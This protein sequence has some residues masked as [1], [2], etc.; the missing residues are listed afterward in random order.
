MNVLL[1]IACLGVAAGLT[2]VRTTLEQVP[3]VDVGGALSAPVDVGEPRNILIIGT[4]S[5]KG[6]DK[7]DPV[8]KGRL[9]GENLADVIM[10]LRVDPTDGS[11]RLLSIP[12]DSRVELPDGSMQ[13]INAAIAGPQGPKNLVQTIKRNF[14]ISIDNYLEVDFAAFK[15]LVEVLGS[16]P[17][18]FTT[19]VR[20][21]TTG[22]YVDNAG[23]ISLSPDQALAYAR[24]RHFE[25]KA[26]N[27][28]KT[29]G[30]GD[31]GRI[32]RQ[33]DFMKRA[34]RRASDLGIRNPS[35]ATGM[36]DA[37]TGA[38]VLDDTLNVGT[39]LDL[40][41]QFRS[42]NPDD[43][44]TEQIPTEAAPRG[45]VAYQDVIWDKAMPMLLPFWAQGDLKPANVIVDVKGSTKISSG[46]QS[47][48]DQ[49]D[50]AGFDAEPVQARGAS[51]ATT[52]TYGPLGR[53]A[54]VLVARY[55]GTVPKLVEDDS[56]VGFRV[57]LNVGS[58]MPTVRAEP[59][60]LDQLPA[61][62]APTTT[63][64]PASGSTASTATPSTTAGDTT[65]T[66]I[67]DGAPDDAAP[68][69]IVPTD[70]ERA[71]ACH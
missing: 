52:L 66:T 16:V 19:P 10:I 31:L 22:L 70:P 18:Y 57:V 2:K 53:D 8:V 28:W 68:P 5:H 40:L 36:V 32:S 54:A 39:I 7:S 6:L 34:I 27:K 42:F 30:T 23:C 59:I 69:G 51:S 12:R 47:V 13:R 29:D 65:T 62:L 4:D 37:A 20:D 49:L 3:V 48:S 46:L 58:D 61:A 63:T 55:L 11:A 71:A 24:S 1:V 35:T 67:L 26:G 43:L 50:T 33:Q 9:E 41:G 21:R 38:V 44:I 17:V 64:T 60:P 25:F 14:G 45:G 15:D 56:I